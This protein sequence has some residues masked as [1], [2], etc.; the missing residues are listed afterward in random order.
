MASTLL[1]RE[2]PALAL[3]TGCIQW[4]IAAIAND[5]YLVFHPDKETFKQ[6]LLKKQIMVDQIINE[7]GKAN[8]AHFFQVWTRS[9]DRLCE[10][11]RG[12]YQKALFAHT[13]IISWHV[14]F[15]YHL[16]LHVHYI[17]QALLDIFVKTQ[18]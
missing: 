18:G 9:M 1:H 12:N 2:L 4:E 11:G 8:V 14:Y 15:T 16:K 13:H 17:A 10:V 3:L 5:T 6:R 7:E